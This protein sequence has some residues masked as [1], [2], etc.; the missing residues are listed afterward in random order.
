MVSYRFRDERGTR[1]KLVTK[2]A[3]IVYVLN[4]IG[5][6]LKVVK[7]NSEDVIIS[8]TNSEVEVTIQKNV[9]VIQCQSKVPDGGVELSLPSN[10]KINVYE[11]AQKDES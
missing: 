9:V 6:G 8:S 4:A 1:M 10:S 5:S 7:Q 11:I 3:H 2:A